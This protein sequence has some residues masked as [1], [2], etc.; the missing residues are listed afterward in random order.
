MGRLIDMTGRIFGRL[1]V[2]RLEDKLPTGECRWLCECSCGGTTIVAGRYLRT[3]RTKSCG[4]LHREAS[5]QR[6]V[7]RNVRGIPQR[8]QRGKRRKRNVPE[9]SLRA[10]VE[11]GEVLR[12]QDVSELCGGADRIDQDDR[13][14]DKDHSGS[15]ADSAV[16]GRDKTLTLCCSA[17]HKA[18]AIRHDDP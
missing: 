9:H 1:T 15:E 10:S 8:A 16:S 14:P 2:T 6:C 7:E 5:R 12:Q 18:A 13:K 11:S 4:C 3:G 17:K